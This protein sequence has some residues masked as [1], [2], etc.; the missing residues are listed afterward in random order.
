VQDGIGAP[1]TCDNVYAVDLNAWMAAHPSL[2]PE[3]G[4][5][6]FLQAWFRDPGNGSNKDTSFSDALRAVVTP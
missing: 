5:T 6:V 4:S 3:A 1:G 2:A